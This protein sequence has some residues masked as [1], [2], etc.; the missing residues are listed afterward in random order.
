LNGLA[1]CE[2][3]LSSHP[4]NVVKKDKGVSNKKGKQFARKNALQRKI[5]FKDSEKSLL[6]FAQSLCVNIF[7]QFTVPDNYLSKAHM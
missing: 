2:Q 3:S 6:L 5:F 7:Y 4:T 1:V